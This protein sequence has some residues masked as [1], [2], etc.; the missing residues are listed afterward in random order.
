MFSNNLVSMTICKSTLTS[1]V[2]AFEGESDGEDVGVPVLG[3]NVGSEV[4]GELDGDA[5]ISSLFSKAASPIVTSGTNGFD[6]PS[7]PAAALFS[8]G[9]RSRMMGCSSSCGWVDVTVDDSA[10][11]V[12]SVLL[13]FGIPAANPIMSISTAAPAMIHPKRCF[14]LLSLFRC[15][16]LAAALDAAEATN[17]DVAATPVSTSPSIVNESLLAVSLIVSMVLSRSSFFVKD[18]MDSRRVESKEMYGG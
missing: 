1:L 12:S 2:G 7:S 16:C 6:D 10:A 4:T 18:M 15:C 5:M 14:F 9:D 3:L 8:A 11:E 17:A 13:F